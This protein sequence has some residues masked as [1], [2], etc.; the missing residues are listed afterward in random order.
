M[1]RGSSV[2]VFLLA[3]VIA[4]CS[5]SPTRP[6]SRDSG[7]TPGTD[8]GPPLPSTDGG[9]LVPIDAGPPREGDGDNDGL[10]DSDEMARGTD[11]TREDT[12]GDGYSDGVEVLAGTRPTDAT[13]RIPPED[14]YV[15]LPY[16][17]PSVIRELSF[18]GRLARG[19]VFFLIDTT[20]SMGLAIDN[21]RTSLSTTIVPAIR[22]R[23]VDVVMGV[24]DYR[25]F[26]VSPYGDPG[27]WPFLVRQTM[28]SD[29]AAVQTAL[30]RLEAGGGADVPE[31]SVEALH[32]SVSGTSCPDSFGAACFRNDSVPIVVAV[33]DA[34][35]H[36]GPGDA[37]PYAGLSARSWSETTA[38]LVGAGVKVVGVAIDQTPPGFPFP[39]PVPA[40]P[41]LEALTTATDSRA[42]DGTLTV[43]NA[44]GGSVSTSLVDGIAALAGARQ[45]D[46]TSARRDDPTDPESIDATRF[47]LRVTPLR[48]TRATRFDATTFYG[49]AGGTEI[50]FEVE[51]R[52][53]F[54]PAQ[55]HVQIFRAFI[56]VVE[57][58]SGIAV[59][60]R[61]V[62]VV[63]PAIG[64]VLI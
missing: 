27:D 19:D 37:N 16:E 57:V 22:D 1:S 23:F 51:F 34:Q 47:I 54:L 39:L 53:T 33:T 44:P 11:P 45:Q 24:G 32:A 4:G 61:N 35:F 50:V 52:N 13:S 62:Y 14:F 18:I 41:H 55:A 2:L 58:E 40:R 3:L 21:V 17:D 36:N 7:V 56:D 31:S 5:E 43:Y 48:A 15:V 59:D 46:I 10:P 42:F 38:A 8:S 28:T 64:G 12:D 6:R 30:N 49:V 9:P 20:A 29:V 60:S 63:V 26:P 25:D